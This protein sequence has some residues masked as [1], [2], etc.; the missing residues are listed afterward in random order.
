LTNSFRLYENF[1]F[2]KEIK[3]PISIHGKN[4]MITKLAAN[5]EE[6]TWMVADED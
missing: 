4:R 3:A 1:S 6:P 2:V 5:K